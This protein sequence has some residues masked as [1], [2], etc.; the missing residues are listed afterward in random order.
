MDT[1]PSTCTKVNTPPPASSKGKKSEPFVVPAAAFITK[2]ALVVPNMFKSICAG[3]P[4][5]ADKF[6]CGFKTRLPSLVRKSMLVGTEF[7]MSTKCDAGAAAPTIVNGTVAGF[8]PVIVTGGAKAPPTTTIGVNRLSKIFTTGGFTE[9][10]IHM[11]PNDGLSDGSF[12]L[13]VGTNVRL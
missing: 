6:A 13:I 1:L 8:V 10:S 3:P 4:S 11:S 5:P 7:V 12:S 9:M 2:P